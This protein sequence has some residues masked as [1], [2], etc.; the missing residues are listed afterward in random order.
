[1]P[2][3]VPRPATG[4]SQELVSR[5]DYLQKLLKHLP[6]SLPLD[7]AES[8]Y[9]FYLNED[10]VATAGTTYPAAERALQL[11]FEIGT[12]DS[13]VKFK[14]RGSRVN[15]LG[16]FLKRAVKRMTSSERDLFQKAWVDR[17]VRAA[18]DSGAAI[19]SK[20][21][22]REPGE[23]EP[24]EQ[25]PAKKTRV[26]APSAPM[27]ISSDDDMPLF[28]LASL[29]SGPKQTLAPDTIIPSTS[30]VDLSNNKQ[31][32]L[33]TMGW[34]GWLPGA[35][36]AHVKKTNN[37]HREGME[38]TV[39]AEE[40]KQEQKKE[41]ERQLNAARQRRFRE[42]KKAE[43]DDDSDLSDDSNAHTALMRGA[44]AAAHERKVNVAE[45][46][47]AG[48]Q[49]WRFELNGTKGGTIRKRASQVNW[50]HPFL[51]GPIDKQMRRTG[52][53]PSATVRNLQCESPLYKT[54]H[55][56][57]LSRWQVKGKNEWKDETTKKIAAGKAITASGRTGILAPYPDITKH[58]KEILR[59]LRMAGGIVNVPI[60]RALLIAEISEQAP[61]LLNQFK[62]SE[63]FVRTFL[64]SVM[65]W[66]PRKATRAAQHI[67]TDAPILMTRTFFRLRYA[68]L[69]GRIP[70][71]VCFLVI[72]LVWYLTFIPACYQCRSSRKL[73]APLKLP[74]IS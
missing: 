49:A 56:G 15:A 72:E 17:L 24:D 6:L 53:S 43:E 61:Q 64:A 40:A 22:E 13:L 20:S 21:R 38:K 31:A 32:T 57:N 70:P 63:K 19:P 36:E 23:D 55:K 30:G 14:E 9:Q 16:P 12:R 18:K 47:H 58:V 59:G 73:S 44:D 46:S 4:P 52:W 50:Y 7:P 35:K 60:V 37:R 2:P 68:I 67:P 41:R 8:P 3:K 33:A 5:I 74:H 39:H 54:L 34:Q 71:E 62:A 10:E 25:R 29:S 69:T 51:F 42:R 26:D 48:T 27:T 1:M 65:D 11:S 28:S 45:I 66:T